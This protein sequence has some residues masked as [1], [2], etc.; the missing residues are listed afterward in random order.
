MENLSDQSFIPTNLDRVDE[1][2]IPRATR[3]HK[4]VCNKLRYCSGFL[5]QAERDR[6]RPFV[7]V[8][9]RS[10]SRT[11]LLGIEPIY[12]DISVVGANS[13]RLPGA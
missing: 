7:G 1:E 10:P 6:K 9:A 8:A 4:V 5:L 13:R 11:H 3:Y 2:M 12:I